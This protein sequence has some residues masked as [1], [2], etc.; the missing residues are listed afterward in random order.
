VKVLIID[1]KEPQGTVRKWAKKN[2]FTF[3]VLLDDGKIAASYAR[4]DVLPDLPREETVIASNL[5]IDRAGRIRFYSLLDTAS[6]DAR[7]VA[8]TKRLDEVIAES[9]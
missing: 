8:L 9:P 6:F 7:L 1:V 4:P 3:P 2:S 5:V